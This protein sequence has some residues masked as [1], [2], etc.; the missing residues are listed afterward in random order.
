MHLVHN[1]N[2]IVIGLPLGI[3]LSCAAVAMGS[4]YLGIDIGFG[5]GLITWGVTLGGIA[6]FVLNILGEIL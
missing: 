1:E 4:K 3:W 6:Y 5:L 2:H